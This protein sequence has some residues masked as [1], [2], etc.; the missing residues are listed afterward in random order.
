MGTPFFKTTLKIQLKGH[1]GGHT[2]AWGPKGGIQVMLEVKQGVL[3]EVLQVIQ[4]IMQ[5][6]IQGVIQ[7]IIQEVIQG[8]MQEAIQGII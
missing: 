8:V 2:G 7:D 6:A 4:G 5:E 3:H 1:A